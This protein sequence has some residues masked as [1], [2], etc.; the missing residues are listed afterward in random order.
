LR[1][2]QYFPHIIIL[3]SFLFAVAA[4]V[5]SA[6]RIKVD[7]QPISPEDLTLKDNPASPG[8]SAMI[9][10]RELV[11]DGWDISTTEYVRIKIFTDEGRKW[12][13]VQIPFAPGVWDIKDLRA[14]TIHPDGSIVEFKGEVFDETAV[15]IRGFKIRL[16]KFSLPDAQ[17][18]SIIEYIY[19]RQY[20]YRVLPPNGWTVQGGLYTRLGLFVF[21]PLQESGLGWREHGLPSELAP[22]KQKDGSFRLEVH[23]LPGVMDED[24]MPPDKLVRAHVDFFNRYAPFQGNE[25]A[26][27]YWKQVGKLWSKNVEKFIDKRDILDKVVAQTARAEDP[28]E[29]RLRKL[30][31]RVQQIQNLDY[32]S[33]ETAGKRNV[34]YPNESVEDVIKHGYGTSTQINYVFVGLARA[35]GFQSSSVAFTPRDEDFFS[36]NLQDPRQLT[37]DLVYVHLGSQDRYLDPGDPYFPYSLLPWYASEAQGIRLEPDGGVI[38]VTSV[39]S[40][41]DATL[42]RHAELQLGADGSISGELQIDFTGQRGCIRREEAWGKTEVDR[43]KNL[44]DQIKSWLPAD[45]TFDVTGVTGWDS[46]SAPLH[47]EG[48]L[49][50]RGYAAAVT[51]RILV[52]IAIFRASQVH[53]FRSATRVSPIYFPYPY[54]EWDEITLKLPVGYTVEGLPPGEKTPQ[55]LVG[56]ELAAMPDGATIHVHRRLVVDAYSFPVTAYPSLRSFFQTAASADGQQIVLQMPQ[57]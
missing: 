23:D 12:A 18:G 40:S 38:V 31:A 3:V 55:S 28:P 19:R 21:R 45:S 34:L 48:T 57:F 20:G 1:K 42:V 43:Q 4:S 24:F 8:D 32:E 16:K 41:S 56:F 33:E 22:Q 14:R 17:P 50:I 39:P 27:E 53:S 36:P 54:Q 6:N 44:S 25:T 46:N 26:A 37:G 15:K 30:Y 51:N 5:H 52:P 47:V 49:Q 9:L 11:I 2:A 13:D 7:W 35:A 10:Y 29:V